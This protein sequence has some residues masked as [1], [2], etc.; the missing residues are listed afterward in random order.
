MTRRADFPEPIQVQFADESRCCL[1]RRSC[2]RLRTAGPPVWKRSASV[3]TVSPS[4]FQCRGDGCILHSHPELLGKDSLR[5]ALFSSSL[6]V[7]GFGPCGGRLSWEPA[8]GLSGWSP[9]FSKATPENPH[10]DPGRN[11]G[12]PLLR[13]P[14]QLMGP[15]E[16][17][18]PRG[19]PVYLGS[20]LCPSSER[21]GQKGL[22]PGSQ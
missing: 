22:R 19:K 21:S 11:H 8:S 12:S 18:A 13:A 3:T 2:L 15:A 16:P 10:L 17:Q 5:T 20:I 9:C 1:S 6:A 14:H 7:S 4:S